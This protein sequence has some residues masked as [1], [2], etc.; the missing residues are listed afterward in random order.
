MICEDFKQHDIRE[1][2]V[3]QARVLRVADQPIGIVR[4]DCYLGGS[5]AWFECPWCEKRCAKLYEIGPALKCRKCAGLHY[6]SEHLCP[7]LRA[8]HKAIKIRKH[9]GQDD[10]RLDR[11]FPEKPKRMRWSTY[12]RLRAEHDKALQ[13]WLAFLNRRAAALQRQVR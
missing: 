10:N 1:I 11:P 13:I 7:D 5:R 8:R 9:L 12:A 3:G 2:Y 4:T 6:R